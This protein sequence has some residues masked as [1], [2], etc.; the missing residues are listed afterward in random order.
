MF[1]GGGVL[2]R[3]GGVPGRI[4]TPGS[5]SVPGVGGSVGCID[6]LSGRWQVFNTDAGNSFSVGAAI[7]VRVNGSKASA[8]SRGV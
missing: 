4:T 6:W 5:R 2:R 7:G 1:G 3:G 8:N